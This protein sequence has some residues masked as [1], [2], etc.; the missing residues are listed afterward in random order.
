LLALQLIV[1]GY[2]GNLPTDLTGRY[3]VVY[4]DAYRHVRGFTPSSANNAAVSYSQFISRLMTAR[5]LIPH[6]W[7]DHRPPVYV[8]TAQQTAAYLAAYDYASLKQYK[9]FSIQFASSSQWRLVLRTPP[10]ELFRLRG[11]QY[12]NP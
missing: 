8:L 12:D 2:S 5:H 11:S 3:N 9:A 4:E 6:Q 7:S 1:I 10:A